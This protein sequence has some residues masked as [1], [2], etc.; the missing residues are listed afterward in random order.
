VPI[1]AT[2]NAARGFGFD[3]G[4]GSNNSFAD[5]GRLPAPNGLAGI[6]SQFNTPLQQF[7][8]VTEQVTTFVDTVVS[9]NLDL[10]KTIADYDLLLKNMPKVSAA[11]QQMFADVFALRDEFVAFTNAVD[12]LKGNVRGALF[13]IV[14][15]AEKQQYL[16]EDLAK[17]FGDLKIAV[18]GSVQELISLGKSIDHTTASGL[19]LAAAFPSLVSA[20]KATQDGVESLINSLRDE[21]GFKTLF[22]YNFY[23][24]I[25]SN[26]TNEFANRYVDGY[27]PTYGESNNT[28]VAFNPV[29]TQ[30]DNTTISTSDPNLVS[31]VRDMAARIDKL[32]LA[33]DRTQA[34][35]KQT[36]DVLR[37]AVSPA[38][39]VSIQTKVIA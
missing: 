27:K 3:G 13:G 37:D 33:L 34:N 35:T 5:F 38:D 2:T 30:R 6:L 21:S 10:P 19:D 12:G 8:A 11:Q 36:A 17:I 20:F 29:V 32:Q 14:S 39:G 1:A 18:P 25:A 26:Y 4:I 15:D 23:K 22:D 9:R 31:A 7:K 16:N 28:S 24:G